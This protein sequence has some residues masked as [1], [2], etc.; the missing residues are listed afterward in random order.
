MLDQK[1]LES[2]PMGANP[3]HYDH[4]SVGMT[5]EQIGLKHVYVMDSG[6]LG[7]GLYIYNQE[8]GDRVKILGVNHPGND[9]IEETLSI[10][11]PYLKQ[12]QLTDAQAARIGRTLYANLRQA[13]RD[14]ERSN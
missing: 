14:K 6:R 13:E 3:F 5:L 12:D 2:F 10:M 4:I 1:L 7:Q 11:Q 8:T 9:A